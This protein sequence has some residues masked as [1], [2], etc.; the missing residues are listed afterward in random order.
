M[1]KTTREKEREFFEAERKRVPHLFEREPMVDSFE[2]QKWIG[3]EVFPDT[4]PLGYLRL[5]PQDFIVEEVARDGTVHTVDVDPSPATSFEG[6]TVYADLVK[7]GISTLEA[8]S[9]IAEALSLQPQSIGFAGIK[10]R[11]ALTSQAISIRDA[12]EADILKVQAD[13]FFLKNIHQGKGALAN[14]DL[15]G[16]R[17][18]IVLRLQRPP[19]EKEVLKTHETLKQIKEEGF[20]NFFSFQRFGTPRLLSHK[21]GL[22]IIKGEFEEAVKMFLV[23]Q[24]LRE[25]PYFKH[26]REE[27]E[28][29]WGNWEG[30]K[31]LL[32]PFPA[33]FPIELQF[34]E[35]LLGNPKDFLG[36][37]HTVPDQV[38]LWVYAY[39]SY[40]F[41]RKLSQFIKGGEVP[42]NLPLLTS[43][44]PR[45]WEPYKEFLEEDSV[46]IPSK[47]YKKFPFIRVASR[48]WPVLQ[49]VEIHNIAFQDNFVL[50]AFSLPK[51]TYATTLLM[52]FFTLASGLPIIPG[53]TNKEIDAKAL[54]G[55]GS[56][57]ATL[58]RFKTVLELREQDI[59]GEFE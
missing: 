57:Q 41:N 40:L 6:K 30:M 35:H 56:T 7:I 24:S 8:Q 55:L 53:I 39:D 20:W 51:G 2:F 34:V 49:R 52:N 11:L 5:M 17:F 15:Q 13:N 37:L 4:L 29:Q 47:Y 54:L 1:D 9:Q 32:S 12:A 28:K 16:N 46:D 38:R 44:S 27:M 45:D 31:T 42:I 18:T 59:S 14:G 26:I 19:S 21:L 36:A 25:L 33:H 50:F 22:R 23:H 10:D 48:T 43:F 3:I 58:E